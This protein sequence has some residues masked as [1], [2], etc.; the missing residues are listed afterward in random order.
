MVP[1]PTRIGEALVEERVR[2]RGEEVRVGAGTDEEVLVGL[3]GGLGPAGVDDDQ[4]TAA[5]P[6]RAEPPGEVRRGEEAAVR[7]ERVRA[8]QEEVV[9]AVDVGDRDREPGAEHQAGRDLLG[10]L[11]EG[12][13]REH[14]ARPEGVEQR[15]VVQQPGQVVDVRVAEV[16][17]DGVSPVPVEDRGEAGLDHRE[18]LRPVDRLPVA[19]RA[20]ERASDPVGVGVEPAEGAALRA[21]EPVAEHVV[22]VAPHEGDVAPVEVQLEAAGGL[23]EGAGA[24]R[25]RHDSE[26]YAAGRR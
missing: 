18:R 20:H 9:G 12:A 4:P 6:Q 17:R 26:G 2:E 11:V 19:V 13:G 16:H 1:Q 5:G 15:P 14:V 21:E 8:E 3:V 10:H 24:N 7:G 25:D 23:A 22:V